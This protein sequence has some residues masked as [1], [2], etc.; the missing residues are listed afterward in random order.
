MK[1]LVLSKHD[2]SQAKARDLFA[3]EIGEVSGAGCDLF[4]VKYKLETEDWSTCKCDCQ[5]PPNPN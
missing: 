4:S 2:A 5:Q 1:S 3:A